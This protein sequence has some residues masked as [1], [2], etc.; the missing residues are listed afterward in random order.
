MKKYI[1]GIDEG[2]TS[3]RSILFDIT[4]NEIVDISS[5]SF[6]STYPHSGWVEQDAEEIY[7]LQLE[8]IK[9][10][11]SK[12]KSKNIIGMGIANQRE[13]IVAWNKKTKKPIYNAIV[14]Q[15]RRTVQF[16]ESLPQNVIASI[17]QKTGL[18][19][20]AYFSASKIKWLIDNVP[21]VKKLME[22]DNL[23]VGTMDSF[24]AYK[25][26]G[27]FVTDVTNASRTML[28]NINTL[29]YDDELLAY[30]NIS[31]SILPKVISN[32]EVIG[33]V[34]E[35]DFPL[36]SL[37]GD[38]QAS[39]FGQGCFTIGK[40]KATYGTGGFLLL[41]IGEKPIFVDKILTTVAFKTGKKVCYALEGSIYS[42]S[43]T[44]NFM[45]DNL[46]FFFNP[47]DTD[48]MA[49]SV[50]NTNGVYFV[51][52]FTGLGAPYWNSDARA[53]ICGIGFDTQKEHIVRAGLES[54]AYNT[55]AIL[56]EMS[57]GGATVKRIKVDGG[58]SK[59]KFLLQFLADINNIKVIKN[60]ESEA[61]ALGAIYL[62][63]LALKVFNYQKLN[64]IIESSAVYSSKMKEEER[65]K[66]Y[67]GWQKAVKMAINN[68]R[69]CFATDVN[70]LPSH[71]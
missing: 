47:A 37:V 32:S 26:T 62:A 67:N 42:A 64:K 58:C 2:T 23:C 34:L 12:V 25:L 36:A 50:K 1:I 70:K 19:A 31:R 10:L 65:Q 29:D 54:M 8:T 35:Y 9:D 69:S 14:W 56:D 18:I 28:F 20:D 49:K 53:L 66:L 27:K 45:K 40:A 41:N 61:T 30:F 4:K 68:I 52:A 24:L 57:N 5:R 33:N 16:I 7:N 21:Q 63:G 39:L 71:T 17:K 55:K 38:Q 11:V 51:P 15:C 44:V 60:K 3:C 48:N 13:T 43:S 6:K 22:E 59:N 46:G